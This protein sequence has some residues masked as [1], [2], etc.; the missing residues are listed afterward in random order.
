MKTPKT[1]VV[2]DGL[3]FKK[4]NLINWHCNSTFWLEGK[5]R[6]LRDVAA[7]TTKE[8]ARLLSFYS[9]EK[10]L[11]DLF[12]F[13]C[14][15]GWIFRLV[16]DC[17]LTAKY[18][19]IDFNERFIEALR[20][21]YGQNSDHRF[22]HFD[23]EVPPPAELIAAADVGLNFFNFFELAD[24]S[25]G[26][27]NVAAMLRPTG[28][29]LIVNIDPV[30]QIL[31]VSGSRESFR[32]NLKEYEKYKEQLGYD[33]DIDVGDEPSGRIYKS[34][35]Y[36]TATYVRL[37]KKHGLQIEDYKEIIKT[38]NSVP[39]IYQFSYFVKR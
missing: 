36:S 7:F 38:G 32:E 20:S 10:R 29:L 24:I 11:P 23:L 8:L 15:E 12:D 33:K 19:G 28:R 2:D 30:T 13:G 1:Y 25:A 21:R 35:L 18:T 37:A 27:A 9:G 5:M 39:Q 16:H 31:A 4:D 26:F 14:G 22:Y 34:L 6:H 3:S 17:H